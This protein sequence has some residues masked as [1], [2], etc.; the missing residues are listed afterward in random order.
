[1]YTVADMLL[2]LMQATTCGTC[3][4]C[5]GAWGPG[6]VK[7][8]QHRVLD[9]RARCEFALTE[10]MNWKK[11]RR[12]LQ[13]QCFELRT[14]LEA[15]RDRVL[16]Q[17]TKRA[18]NSLA[19]GVMTGGSVRS[20][21]ASVKLGQDALAMMK[22]SGEQD[23]GTL[24]MA[25]AAIM[26]TRFGGLF[27][28]ALKEMI[29]LQGDVANITSQFGSGCGTFFKFYS[30]LL[31]LAM[32]AT[33]FFAPLL[34]NHFAEN[35]GTFSERMCGSYL[36]CF[37]FLGSF[38]KSSGVAVEQWVTAVE[39]KPSNGNTSLSMFTDIGRE[40]FDE[41]FAA[42]P[43][44]RFVR[45]CRVQALFAGFLDNSTGLSAYDVFTSSWQNMPG[46]QNEDWV[47]YS[48]LADVIQAETP[49][50][51]CSVNDTS[52]GQGFPGICKFSPTSQLTGRW[53]ASA[54]TF[55]GNLPKHGLQ[56]ELWNSSTRC[57]VES[58]ADVRNMVGG[59]PVTV[60]SSG[61]DLWMAFWYFFGNMVSIIF[62]VLFFLGWWQM[63]EATYNYE[64]FTESLEPKGWSSLLLGLWNFRLNSESDRE[65][66]KQTMVSQLRAQ[67]REEKDNEK[68]RKRTLMDVY[69]L[70][71]K[72]LLGFLLNLGIIAGL[73]IAIWI[74]IRD[75]TQLVDSL[76]GSFEQC[77]NARGLGEWLGAT[78]A[79]L[80]VTGAGAVLP[81]VTELL[82]SLE[83]WPQK[84][85]AQLN[86]YRFFLGQ[87]LTAGLYAAICLE[88]LYD[89][90]I[91]TS[92][93]LVLQPQVEPCG[94]YPCKADHAGAEMLS[95][96]VTEFTLMMV[97]PLAKLCWALIRHNLQ[98]LMGR[99]GNFPW[100]VFEIQDDAV[101]VVYFSALLWMCLSTVP[102]MAVIG[103]L[104][105]YLHFKWLRFNLTFLMR[106]PFITD[107][108]G[109]L[110][111]LQRITCI[112][113]IAIG[114]LMMSQLIITV[115]YEPTCGPVDGFRAAGPMIWY[116]D[117]PLKEVWMVVYQVTL[118][119]RGSLLAATCFLMTVLGMMHQVKMKTNR[120]VVEQMSGVANRHVASLE[121]EM[122]RSRQPP[123]RRVTVRHGDRITA[124]VQMQR[125]HLQWT[126]LAYMTML[127]VLQ[128]LG[129]IPLL[130]VDE[131]AQCVEP[132]LF[133]P[134]NWGS[135]AFAL[136]GDE[137]Q[138]PAT[139]L[140]K[141]ASQ[142]DLGVSI[143]ERFVRDE[144]VSLGN[145]FVQLDE[146]Q[147]MHPSIARFPCDAFY[148]GTIRDGAAMSK[149]E[150]IPGFPWPVPGCHVA[151]VECGY[152][153]GEEGG[154]GGGSHSNY[155]EANVLLTVL[156]RC[157]AKGTLPS[158]VG[159]IT[160]YSAQQALLQKEVAKL[161]L[162][163][164]R[165]DTV[166]GF[167]GAERDL[168]LA[169]TVR[170]HYKV[171]FMRDPR[172]VNVLLT[173][174]KRGLVVFG[175]GTTLNSEMET[176][177]P[178]L[179]WIRE[180]GAQ[181]SAEQLVGGADFPGGLDEPWG[182]DPWEA[183]RLPVPTDDRTIHA[184]S[185]PA[186]GPLPP[187]AFPSSNRPASFPPVSTAPSRPASFPPAATAA[188][189]PIGPIRPSQAASFPTGRTYAAAAHSGTTDEDDG[190]RMRQTWLKTA[191]SQPA[192][193]A[194]L[195][196]DNWT[197][198]AAE[199]GR[200]WEHNEVTGESRWKEI[201]K[202]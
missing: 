115:P 145:G 12:T 192:P 129:E 146:Q 44:V 23:S 19:I 16:Q 197:E 151:F 66:W 32:L 175:N 30:Y 84:Y 171:G 108:T 153:T 147:R 65:I 112:N 134:L 126:K 166:D 179:T 148:G 89:W 18:N 193:A 74:C 49:W 118:E 4:T 142:L 111:T 123:E 33:F 110:V 54:E 75:R 149:R 88:L 163:G 77:C 191:V 159:I 132:G 50:P 127:S 52:A 172:R 182:E 64:Q 25:A 5:A 128:S 200:I 78:L 194:W 199:D 183:P 36:P 170:S 187:A 43:M 141:K 1:M 40:A 58:R 198:Y 31:L 95:L 26:R 135:V 94:A 184:T 9:Y 140:S 51:S 83:A 154:M 48:R 137:K 195:E 160:G 180:Q 131:A 15:E 14:S 185:S 165:V 161:G 201:E 38:Y 47:I 56:L 157:L 73:W 86:I 27:I 188:S 92:G 70:V 116:L 169:S 20:G 76:A 181:M 97:K 57:F 102:Y 60:E 117:F 152:M 158:Q 35:R 39:L 93:D 189:G 122:G 28:A 17:T 10:Q 34:L 139:I 3:E 42:C 103:P 202:L 71:L 186:P 79:P 29:P 114:L 41:K 119:N 2:F 130:L 21:R 143:F 168:I 121:R 45:D 120:S 106:R 133:V 82:T 164:L 59:L 13:E 107:T 67:F 87:I 190:L 174:A 90:P 178:W 7:R 68:A 11:E 62:A 124:S 167:Q 173:R 53:F 72:R 101:N 196:K 99:K 177:R 37:L 113:F 100:P 105:L 150:P 176:W 61:K 98:K 8:L 80:L 63:T 155:K 109:L 96:V 144:I 6:L 136:V 91:W 125:V 104:L 85:R 138:L 22:E 81:P 156:K 55:E 46:T 24:D 69:F 162:P